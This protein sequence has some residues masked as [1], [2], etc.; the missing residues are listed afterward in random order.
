VAARR[1]KAAGAFPAAR[2]KLGETAEQAALREL[3][4]ETG[5]SVET[6]YLAG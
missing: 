4:E 3:A 6:L 5:L 1:R 2:K